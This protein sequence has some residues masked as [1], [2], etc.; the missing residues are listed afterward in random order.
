[1]KRDVREF[2]ER[3]S[4]GAA[5]SAEAKQARRKRRMG[6]FIDYL[7]RKAMNLEASG[8]PAGARAF[9]EQW[10]GMLYGR[11]KAAFVETFPPETPE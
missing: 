10:K 3:E 8:N 7:V 2:L 4:V 9:R 11:E 6:R 1:M 5:R